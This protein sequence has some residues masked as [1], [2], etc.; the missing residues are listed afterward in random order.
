MA[1]RPGEEVRIVGG[2]R[3]GKFPAGHRSGCLETARRVGPR[4]SARRPTCK[5]AGVKDLGQVTG[6]N[7]LDLFFQDKPMTL[8]RWPNEGFVNIV[9]IV[10]GKPVRRPRHRRRCDRKISTY[11]GDRPQRW[12]GEKD[13][14][15][16]GYWFWD[17]ADQR[18]QVES[19]DTEKRVISLVPPYHNYGYRKGQWYYAFNLLSE[20]D[21]PGEWYLDRTSGIL[22]FWPPAPLEQGKAVVSVI[23]TAGEHE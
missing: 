21:T 18:E 9:D 2:V 1:S 3:I 19:I 6:D 10:G 17:W 14:W 8:A 5:A 12:P 20:L 4:Q 15:L 7:R 23:P 16:H 13:I 22:Y 11:E